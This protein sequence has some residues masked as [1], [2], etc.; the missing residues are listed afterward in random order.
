[1]EAHSATVE[2]SEASIGHV[3]FATSV[4]NTSVPLPLAISSPLSVLPSVSPAH[5]IPANL[6]K[7]ILEGKDINLASLLIAPQVIVENKPYG[8]FQN[9]GSEA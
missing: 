3:P 1:M 6:K 4:G 8:G 2:F 7:D 9:Q 5:F